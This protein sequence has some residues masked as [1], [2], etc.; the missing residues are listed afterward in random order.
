MVWREHDLEIAPA[1]AKERHLLLKRKPL[2]P[3]RQEPNSR[4]SLGHSFDATEI[5]FITRES[6]QERTKASIGF[7]VNSDG[8]SGA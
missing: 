4:K 5:A 6:D 8:A 7:E 1:I 3:F 2:L